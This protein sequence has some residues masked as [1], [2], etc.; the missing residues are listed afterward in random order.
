MA[1]LTAEELAELAQC[2]AAI[3]G[4]Q[5]AWIECGRALRSIRDRKLY[6]ESS[7]TFDAYVFSRWR[8]VRRRAYQMMDASAVVENVNNCSHFEPALT[9]GA[10][11]P[12]TRLD[13]SA[14][15]EAFLLACN[16]A[17]KDAAGTPLLT[18][19]I[20]A[21]AADKVSPSEKP[22][23]VVKLRRDKEA[24][25]PTADPERAV[26][27]L[28]KTCEQRDLVK[29]YSE[30]GYTLHRIGAITKWA[31]VMREMLNTRG[32]A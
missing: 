13:A 19:K 8:M 32:V 3:V 20:I 7:D 2:E 18:G 4:G 17:P 26:R 6:R 24:T 11:R 16:M 23:N 12:L 31:E 1:A 25:I 30:L 27:I 10:I 22:A 9:E 15:R 28:M 21:T 5:R 14:Q 29:L